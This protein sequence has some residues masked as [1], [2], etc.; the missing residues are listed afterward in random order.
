MHLTPTSNRFGCKNP[1][2]FEPSRSN[3]KKEMKI[4]RKQKQ[5]FYLIMQQP[6]QPLTLRPGECL[7]DEVKN[8]LKNA[9]T[10]YAKSRDFQNYTK[11]LQRILG[12]P[13]FVPFTEQEKIFFGGFIEGEGSISVGAKRSETSQFGVYLDPEFSLT[14]HVNGSIH[15]FRCLCHFRTG[16]IRYKSGSNATLVYTLD[17]RRTLQQV[18]V[19]FFRQYVCPYSSS[20]KRKRFEK[21]CTLLDLFDQGAHQDLNKF[22]YELGPIWD[23][24]R[25]QKGQSNQSFQSL[26][27]FQQYVL[28]FAEQSHASPIAKRGTA[29]LAPLASRW[30]KRGTKLLKFFNLA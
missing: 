18:L 16:L 2:F 30:E 9:N 14:Q 21:W 1:C 29:S 28:L 5:F 25:M 10:K 24:M 19:P 20:G 27:D 23:E 6:F 17:A 12:L 8:A 15:L 22:L 7:S 13:N 4:S 3:A 11:T 26:E